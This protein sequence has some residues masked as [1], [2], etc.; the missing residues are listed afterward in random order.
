MVSFFLENIWKSDGLGWS[1]ELDLDNSFLLEEPGLVGK[2]LLDDTVL[3]LNISWASFC[4]FLLTGGGAF[5]E[6]KSPKS[7]LEI[8]C[9]LSLKF[10]WLSVFPTWWICWSLD[11]KALDL[12]ESWEM[13]SC[14]PI[15]PRGTHFLLARSYEERV[16]CLRTSPELGVSSWSCDE[17]V[18]DMSKSSEE[19]DRAKGASR[20]H[21][22]VLSEV[23]A[24][25]PDVSC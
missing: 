18:L 9:S 14:E 4:W 23:E 3:R 24:R 19:K 16:L 6:K 22:R 21:S 5:L 12:V 17:L 13:D 11:A 15:S 10:S 25:R 20:P 1:W 7:F 8:V 2:R